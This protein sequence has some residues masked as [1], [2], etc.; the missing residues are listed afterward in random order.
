MCLPWELKRDRSRQCLTKSKAP[1]PKQDKWEE[2][3][4][5]HC[6][7]SCRGL[8][9]D[10]SRASTPSWQQGGEG[11]VTSCSFF[12]H[13]LSPLM[14][15]FTASHQHSGAKLLLQCL[16]SILPGA[17]LL[18]PV[19]LVQNQMHLYKAGFSAYIHAAFIFL[20]SNVASNFI[21]Q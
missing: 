7:A 18:P 16:V 5:Q 13:T 3:R 12:A 21:K 15:S 9:T 10:E 4:H 11:G 14:L 17:P 8:G 2:W 20:A 19:Q 1:V 6:K